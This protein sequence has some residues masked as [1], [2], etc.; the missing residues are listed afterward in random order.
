VYRLF[1]TG[2]CGS[3]AKRDDGNRFRLDDWELRDD[4]QSECRALWPQVTT[5][6]LFD[7]TDYAAY[8]AEFLKLFGFGVDA[9]DYAADVD[10]QVPF[11]VID[12]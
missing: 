2:L 12:I 8:K 5:E 4:I 1:S 6:N 7:L 11:D 10:P 3:S 9:V